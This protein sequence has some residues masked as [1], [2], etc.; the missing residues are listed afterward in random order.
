MP[1]EAKF[2]PAP[3]VGT[4]ESS[5]ATRL[6]CG[7]VTPSVSGQAFGCSQPGN[8]KA[9]DKCRE[10]LGALAHRLAQ[11]IT[12]LRGGIEIGLLAKHSAAEYREMLEKSLELADTM[13][14]LVISLRD[15]GES[16]A[17]GGTP[18]FTLLETAVKEVLIEV[19][20]LAESRNLHFELTTQAT[21]EIYVNPGR[22]REALQSLL[23]WVVDNSAGTGVIAVHVAVTH[24]EATLFLFPSRLDFQYLQI[25]MLE[26]ITTL[27]LLFAHASKNGGLGWAISERLIKG[28]GGKMEL[29]TDGSNVGSI[30]VGFPLP[31]ETDLENF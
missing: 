15:L 11:P 29:L 10:C 20:G 1:N 3:S 30:R 22:L 25:K 24:D 8:D 4:P 18:G 2:N 16:G 5:L 27:G 7:T 12:A 13:V 31:P 6:A 21:R 26:D 9:S 14:Q 23:V 19:E 17:P 28:L